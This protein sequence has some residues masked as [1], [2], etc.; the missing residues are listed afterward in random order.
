MAS[1][2]ARIADRLVAVL[3]ARPGTRDRHRPRRSGLRRSRAHATV[4]FD[5]VQA[6]ASIR[7]QSAHLVQLRHEFLPAEA[8]LH[9]HRNTR[10]NSAR[11]SSNGSTGVF[12]LMDTPAGPRSTQ[13]A[14]SATDSSTASSLHW[15]VSV[16]E[17]GVLLHPALRSSIMRWTSRN[18]TVFPIRDLA[19][20]APKERLGTSGRPSH[21]C[22][23]S[24]SRW[25][26]PP[27]QGRRNP[28]RGWRAMM[29]CCPFAGS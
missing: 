12:G 24:A 11:C 23:H 6:S 27:R 25:P 21:R 4:D 2:T 16:V 10:S 9:A 13:G 20:G 22:T 1:A 14:A 7:A 15:K 28:R 3:L 19:T 8:W 29:V 5:E 26:P 18:C 17:V